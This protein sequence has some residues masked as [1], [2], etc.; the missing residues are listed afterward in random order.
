MVNRKTRDMN[1]ISGPRATV[2]LLDICQASTCLIVFE[3]FGLIDAVMSLLRLQ[4]RI[5]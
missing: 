4:S 2:F 3:L 1:R 5:S